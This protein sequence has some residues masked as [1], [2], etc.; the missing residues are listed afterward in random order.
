MKTME[1]TVVRVYSVERAENLPNIL[2]YLQKEAQVRGFSVFRAISGFGETG[3]HA[4]MFLDVSFSLPLVIEFF[5]QPEK[6]SKI[7]DHLNTLIKSE[8]IIFFSAQTNA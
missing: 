2:N 7:L 3:V 6:I 8:H 4:G 1:V 5:D